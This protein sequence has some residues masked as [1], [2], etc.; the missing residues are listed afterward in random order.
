[1][2]ELYKKYSK[3][4]YNYLNSLSGNTSIAEELTQETFYKA[5]KGINK[6]NNECKISTWLCKIAKNAWNDYLRKERS[7]NLVSINYEDYIEKIIFEKSFEEKIED[8]SE[9]IS[10]YKYIHTLD[11]NTREVFYLRLK[12]ELSFKEIGEILNKSEDWSRLTFYRGKIKLKEAMKDE[13][14]M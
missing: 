3:L 9:I 14:R 1:M 7:Q 10:L 4:V 6:F 5:I 12:G 11:E 13:K 2:D 8:K